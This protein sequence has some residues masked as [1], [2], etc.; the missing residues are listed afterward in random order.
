M[1]RYKRKNG[2]APASLVAQGYDAMMLLADAIK[3]AKTTERD[4]VREALAATKDYPAITGTITLDENRNATK[5]A[6]VLQI[7]GD[8]FAYKKTI[9]PTTGGK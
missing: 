1:K 9:E 3:R 6:V 5:S 7:Q 8:K 2:Q 4:K